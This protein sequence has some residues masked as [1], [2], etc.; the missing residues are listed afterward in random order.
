MGFSPEIEVAIVRARAELSRSHHDLVRRDL[1]TSDEAQISVRVPG[2]DL[3]VITSVD[4]HYDDVAPENLVVCDLRGVVA[5]DSLGSELSPALE[6]AAHGYLYRTM[7]EVG[8]VVHTHSPYAVAWAAISEPIPSVLTTVAARFGGDIPV[9]PLVTS[10]DESLGHAIADVLAGAR[11][12]AVLM[13]GHGPFTVGAD[14]RA[15]VDRA[16]QVEEVARAVY[17]ARGVGDPQALAQTDVDALFA[18]RDAP[19]SR[20]AAPA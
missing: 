16:L 15:A 1:V 8:A 17:L 12:R 10:S 9:G 2:A 20:L 5:S 6:A 14:A 4:V 7:P 19:G 3:L 11:S 13:R 18:A